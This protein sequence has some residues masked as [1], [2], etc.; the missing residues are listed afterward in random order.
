MENSYT[1]TSTLDSK[2]ALRPPLFENL[3]LHVFILY[4]AGKWHLGFR[5]ESLTPTYRGYDT[6]LGYYHMVLEH[7][8]FSSLPL[9]HM[10]TSV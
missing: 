7:V 2:S 9:T 8:V 4:R 1:R 6:F 3:R 5:N 10:L